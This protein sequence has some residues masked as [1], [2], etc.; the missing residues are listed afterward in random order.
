MQ[1]GVGDDILSGGGGNDLLDG[2]LG[3][4]TLMGVRAISSTMWAMWSNCERRHGHGVGS[5]LGA[6]LE[7]LTWAIPGTTC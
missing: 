4:D 3:E 6:N 1:G 7:N 5:P 2:G